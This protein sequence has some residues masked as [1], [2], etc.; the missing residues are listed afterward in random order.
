MEPRLLPALVQSFSSLNSHNQRWREFFEA[1]LKRDQSIAR[2]LV[3]NGV[4]LEI[5]DE[6]GAMVL[7]HSVRRG[8]TSMATFLIKNGSNVN[9]ALEG[10]TA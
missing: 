7:D 10:Y 1:A 4:D 2:P 5:K 6:I 3:M 9:I 8:D